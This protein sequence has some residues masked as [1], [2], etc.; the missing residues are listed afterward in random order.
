[1]GMHRHERNVRASPAGL[2][3]RDPS[4]YVDASMVDA[5]DKTLEV[6]AS[7]SRHGV[8]YALVGGVALNIHGIVRATEDI[9]LFV[10]PTVDNIERLRRALRDVWDDP[11]IAKITAADLCGDYPAVRYGPP[12]AT[13][14]LDI[15]TR[16]GEAFSYDD[17]EVET[18][19]VG[20][21]DVRVVTPRMLYRMKRD[22]VRPLDRADAEALRIAFDIT[23]PE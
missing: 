4:C 2:P 13:L 10:R 19:H 8:E 11:E 3:W 9:D 20:N 21:V 18:Q 23:D 7:L 16:L 12:E 5:L 14:Y 6:L 17:L 1:M 22:T 15:L